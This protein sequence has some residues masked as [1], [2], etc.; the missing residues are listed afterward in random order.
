MSM[1]SAYCHK[2]KSHKVQKVTVPTPLYAHP[3][4]TMGG[5]LE[6]LFAMKECLVR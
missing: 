3:S 1:E 5:E 6:C 4:P 2:V